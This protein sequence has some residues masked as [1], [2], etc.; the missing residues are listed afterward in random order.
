MKQQ[1]QLQERHH[2][3]EQFR[4]IVNAWGIHFFFFAFARS[5]FVFA[6]RALTAL[7][8]AALRSSGVMFAALASPPRFPITRVSI[9]AISEKI[10]AHT[11][12]VSPLTC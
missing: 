10:L 6:H 9:K 2:R 8:A 4:V 7:L 12:Y 5:F 3:I 1:G 11:R